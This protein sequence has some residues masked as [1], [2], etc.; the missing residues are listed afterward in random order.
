MRRDRTAAEVV[1]EEH[2][3]STSGVEPRRSGRRRRRRRKGARA[4]R[5]YLL[6]HLLTTGNLFFGF[7]AIVHAFTG[8]P[9][10]AALGIIL[11]AAFDTL[12][13]RVARMTHSTSRFGVEY[14]SIADTVSFGVAPAM[15]AFSAG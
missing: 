10:K 14:D 12:D 2:E 13:G 3:A 9:D 7:Y 11:A 1:M 4:S 6:P 8:D 5:M 15:L